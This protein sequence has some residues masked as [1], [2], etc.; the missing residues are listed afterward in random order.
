MPQDLKWVAWSLHEE[1]VLQNILDRQWV[2]K[3]GR[4][5]EQFLVLTPYN[6]VPVVRCV[7]GPLLLVAHS[8]QPFV[9]LLIFQ[10]KAIAREMLSVPK[11]TAKPFRTA[12]HRQ[13]A[14]KG[15]ETIVNRSHMKT[16]CGFT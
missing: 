11:P 15:K 10:I 1:Y 8:Q 3:A 2:Y 9:H 4:N 16:D 7:A 5:L 6:G 12:D 14:V 13:G